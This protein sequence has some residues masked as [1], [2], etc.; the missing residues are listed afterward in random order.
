MIKLMYT[1]LQEQPAF[2]CARNLTI[3]EFS[4]QKYVESESMFVIPCLNHK[5]AAKGI[6]QLTVI[7][8]DEATLIK[9]HT[10]VR[11]R[12]TAQKGVRTLCI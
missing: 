8:D 9:Y 1:C 3:Q 6:A 2:W 7:S 4:Q 5:T 11:A 10:L 12:I